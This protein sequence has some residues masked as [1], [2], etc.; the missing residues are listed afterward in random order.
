MLADF[1]PK[2]LVAGAASGHAT[3]DQWDEDV[4][5]GLDR[6][7]VMVGLL[8]LLTKTSTCATAKIGTTV[9]VQD[10][11]DSGAPILPGT[12]YRVADRQ[13][14]LECADGR[15]TRLLLQPVG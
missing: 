13:R 4:Q 5:P 11:D 1:E 14:P 9:T 12:V 15:L 6:K 2:W 3:A 7:G 10:T 8:A